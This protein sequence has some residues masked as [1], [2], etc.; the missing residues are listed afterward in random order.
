[1]T[2]ISYRRGPALQGMAVK[3][4]PLEVYVSWISTPANCGGKLLSKEKLD[5]RRIIS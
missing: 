2:I 4:L 1:M 5:N 3:V